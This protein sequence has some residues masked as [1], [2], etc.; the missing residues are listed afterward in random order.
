[1]A[2]KFIFF[3]L[4]SSASFGVSAS[5]LLLTDGQMDSVSASGTFASSFARVNNISTS[6]SS[7][8]R[9]RS[10]STSRAFAAN[11]QFGDLG[12]G[13]VSVA[14]C[15]TSSSNVSGVDQAV[16]FSQHGL[17]ISIGVAG[18]GIL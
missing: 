14:C 13:A 1:M 16:N 17:S 6:A 7:T 3:A 11:S 10:F 4:L 18:L 8:G 2:I 5:K 12:G 9:Y 15:G